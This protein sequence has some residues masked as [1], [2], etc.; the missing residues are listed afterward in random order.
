MCVILDNQ[1]LDCFFC[2]SGSGGVRES[3]KKTLIRSNGDRTE[4]VI[5]IVSQKV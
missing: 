2:D 5:G 1:V 4:I 3:M